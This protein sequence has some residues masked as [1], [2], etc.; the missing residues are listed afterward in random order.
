MSCVDLRY[1]NDELIF[2]LEKI[3]YYNFLFFVA[4]TSQQPN[5]LVGM[6]LSPNGLR[7][8]KKG[9]VQIYLSPTRR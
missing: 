4:A 3:Y 6:R 5:H 8:R 9:A 2:R 1:W 7:S